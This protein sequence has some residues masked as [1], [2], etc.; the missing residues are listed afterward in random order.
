MRVTVQAGKQPV[1]VPTNFFK[2]VSIDPN[3][4]SRVVVHYQVDQTD[5][6]K[7]K[8]TR[9]RV[10]VFQQKAPSPKITDVDTLDGMA[11]NASKQRFDSGVI[12]E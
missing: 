3:G 6:V 8:L 9:V 10:S 2:L 7:N 11:V 5:V 1:S 4:G 12:Y